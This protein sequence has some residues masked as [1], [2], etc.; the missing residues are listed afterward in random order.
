VFCLLEKA[1]STGVVRAGQAAQS[2]SCGETRR[3]P[4]ALQS[5]AQ[6]GQGQNCIEVKYHDLPLIVPSDIPANENS[7]KNRIRSRKSGRFRQRRW[8]IV[9]NRIQFRHKAF[10][11]K[12]LPIA[13]TW[14]LN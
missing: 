4:W 6:R 7:G 9:G 5:T 14:E 13:G 2:S 3:L 12:E 10:S 1:R 8:N 11:S